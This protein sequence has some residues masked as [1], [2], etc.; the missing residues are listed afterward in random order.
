MFL[1]I[2]YW[3]RHGWSISVTQY[4]AK[5]L[6]KVDLSKWYF[7][8]K[9]ATIAVVICTTSIVVRSY[10][11]E[12]LLKIMMSQKLDKD[13]QYSVFRCAPVPQS[14]AKYIDVN[15][16]VIKILICETL[17]YWDI[18][19]MLVVCCTQLYNHNIFTFEPG[20]RRCNFAK[21]PPL[22]PW[23]PWFSL[24]YPLIK[25]PFVIFRPLIF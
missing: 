21:T 18:Y 5:K 23:T 4:M 1:D 24:K 10:S 16:S 20:R 2:L 14:N 7:L 19:S 6:V 22:A 11:S 13:G 15:S 12:L 8:L 9:T 17:W 25:G 3:L